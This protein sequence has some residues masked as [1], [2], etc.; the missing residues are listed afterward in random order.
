M[1]ASSE[2]G[3]WVAA[4]TAACCAG[5]SAANASWSLA[6]SIA[7]SVAVPAPSGSRVLE[8]DLRGPQDAVARP[9]GHL[10]EA[11]ALVGGE[12]GDEDEPDDVAEPGRRVGDHRAAVGVADGEDRSRGP[13]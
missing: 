10:A 2:T 9:G 7:N 3:R 4:I 8:R 1:K 11:L 12:R 5:R 13:A 6:G